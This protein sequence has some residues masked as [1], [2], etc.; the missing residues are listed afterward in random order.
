MVII[1]LNGHV[2][3]YVDGYDRVHDWS[4]EFG[5]RNTEGELVLEMSTTLDMVVEFWR[6]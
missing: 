1:D 2:G 6:L 4:N 3:K 5:V